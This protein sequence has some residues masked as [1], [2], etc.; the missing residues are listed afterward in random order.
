LPNGDL[1]TTALQ[2]HA[3][4]A[5]QAAIVRRLRGQRPW[6][7]GTENDLPGPL[8]AVY[9]GEDKSSGGSGRAA[10]EAFDE[11]L[12]ASEVQAIIAPFIV[13]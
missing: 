3:T 6:I 11:P 12:S 5:R 10:T 9:A 13:P 1:L 7:T 8:S 2:I 4:E